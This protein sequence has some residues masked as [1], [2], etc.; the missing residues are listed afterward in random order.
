METKG[1]LKDRL[2]EC[3]QD[4]DDNLLYEYKRIYDHATTTWL[5]LLGQ[6]E[7]SYRGLPHILAVEHWI[8]KMI[9]P[10]L[11]STLTPVEIFLLLT[12]ILFHDIGK[13]E[14]VKASTR[15]DYR[16][17]RT[18]KS[19]RDDLHGQYSCLY[20]LRNW[21][22]LRIF[23]GR[24]ATYIALLSCSHKWRST[25]PGSLETD[26]D[27]QLGDFA[28]LC[29]RA[30][31]L[32]CNP[33]AEQLQPVEVYG[34]GKMRLNWIAALIRLGDEIDV[35]YAR[36]VARELRADSSNEKGW[37]AFIED[38]SFDRT[39]EAVKLLVNRVA[40][41]ITPNAKT[42]LSTTVGRINQVLKNW[43]ESFFEMNLPFR[44]SFWQTPDQCNQL[45]GSDPSPLRDGERWEDLI[46]PSLRN[47]VLTN[48]EEAALHLLNGI[49]DVNRISWNSL[50]AEAGLLRTDLVKLGAERLNRLDSRVE[51]IIS[52]DYV[53]LRHSD[54][55]A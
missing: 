40:D 47:R 13:I 46:E 54:R 6:E 35:T 50:A 4:G 24:I 26:D 8:N 44:E 12:A 32:K 33:N 3:S 31:N 14:G 43:H 10:E 7:G 38:I 15:K 42:D 39:G 48:I 36:T 51:F 25:I 5:P 45:F 17:R 28:Y 30:C 27:N 29:E 18:R 19:K 20:V 53:A 11:L 37:R 23:D 34:Y 1:T 9:T 16:L 22:S 21:P 55:G 41:K 52:D 2:G 49:V